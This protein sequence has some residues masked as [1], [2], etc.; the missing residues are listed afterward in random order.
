MLAVP[1]VPGEHSAADR[2]LVLHV[3]A[4]PADTDEILRAR[5][6]GDLPVCDRFGLCAADDASIVARRPDAA[7]R[8][9]RPRPLADAVSAASLRLGGGISRLRVRDRRSHGVLPFL[10]APPG[11]VAFSASWRVSCAWL[12][13]S[14]TAFRFLGHTRS[15]PD[16]R[17]VCFRPFQP[18]VLAGNTAAGWS[19]GLSAPGEQSPHSEPAVPGRRADRGRRH[20]LSVRS[21]QLR[22]YRPAGSGVLSVGDR[23]PHRRGLRLPGDRGF[24]RGGKVSC[25]FC[26][27]RF[28]PGMTWRSI[29]GWS[30]RNW[31]LETHDFSHHNRPNFAN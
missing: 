5:D 14:W 31:K 16:R 1:L 10:E 9:A 18:A 27:R 7:R 19:V 29:P 21:D 28:R 17:S 13:L 8:I 25:P 24:Y 23:G 12:V 30:T 15:R 6:S 3:A 2:A 22:F 20:A 26:P 11:H 4:V